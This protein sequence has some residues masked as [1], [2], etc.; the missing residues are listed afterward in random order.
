MNKINDAAYNAVKSQPLS[1]LIPPPPAVNDD[2]GGTADTAKQISNFQN[3][4]ITFD[5]ESCD[6]DIFSLPST[7]KPQKVKLTGDL[8]RLLVRKADGKRMDSYFDDWRNSRI[9]FDT[10]TTQ[11][12]YLMKIS[13]ECNGV[14][15]TRTSSIKIEAL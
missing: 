5:L 6:I 10:S 1:K 9:T 7:S 4:T 14:A 11:R 2:I 8:S 12:I 13:L 3:H 15:R